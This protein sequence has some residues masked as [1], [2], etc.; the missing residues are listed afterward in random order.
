MDR[1]DVGNNITGL[2]AVSDEPLE[3]I[4]YLV[5]ILEQSWRVYVDRETVNLNN[6]IKR[7]EIGVGIG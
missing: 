1:Y 3:D 4:K 6:S 7:I 2:I 5:K